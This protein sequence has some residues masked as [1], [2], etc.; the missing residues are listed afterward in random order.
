MVRILYLVRVF[1]NGINGFLKAEKA[2]KMTNVQVDL[3]LF[4]LRK[5]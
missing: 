5:Q 1:S 3:S 2:P 4:Q